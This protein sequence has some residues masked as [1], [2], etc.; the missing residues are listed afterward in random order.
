MTEKE[1]LLKDYEI[2]KA[3]IDKIDRYLFWI[4]NWTI[5]LCSAVIVFALTN[6]SEII[7]ISNFF[8][9]GGFLFLELIQKSFHEDAITHSKKIEKI[10]RESIN[11]NNPLPEDYNFGLGHAIKR[12]TTKKLMK[13][14]INPDRWHNIAFYILVLLFSVSSLIFFPYMPNSAT[15]F[16]PTR[17]NSCIYDIDEPEKEFVD[18]QTKEIDESRLLFSTFVERN[19]KI[20]KKQL[21]LDTLILNTTDTILRIWTIYEATNGG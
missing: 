15:H 19:A 20:A 18:S 13:I 1:I 4:R 17:V 16:K 11:A 8:I 14:F 10:I 12:V 21:R 3:F 6:H 2:T 7:L 5:V 9:I